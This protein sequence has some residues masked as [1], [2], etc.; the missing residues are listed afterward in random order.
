MIKSQSKSEELEENVD[1][2][3]ESNFQSLENITSNSPDY[4]TI[5]FRHQNQNRSLSVANSCLSPK[6]GEK[7]EK[8]SPPQRGIKKKKMNKIGG[9]QTPSKYPQ[10]P[11]NLL[12]SKNHH[13]N[14]TTRI[15]QNLPMYT[16]GRA[17]SHVSGSE[18][19]E[20]ILEERDRQFATAICEF[21]RYI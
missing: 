11:S 6:E 10:I 21:F 1:L 3:S 8:V 16:S 19:N 9:V 17:V 15:Y 4:A 7:S 20:E 12:A 18:D 5:D 13:H 14:S 2:N